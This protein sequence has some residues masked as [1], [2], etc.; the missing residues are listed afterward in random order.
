VP[1][2]LLINQDKI[3]HYR[4]R[5]YNYL[6]TFL[7]QQD[8]NLALVS[9][10]VEDGNSHPITFDHRVISLRTMP[11]ARFIIKE[12]P[13]IIIYWIKL[14][15]MYLFPVLFMVKFLGKKS[16]YWGHGRDLYGR[17]ALKLKKL[18]HHL[19]FMLS[20]ALLLYGEHLKSGVSRRFHGKTFTANNTLYFDGYENRPVDR[21][22]CLARFGISTNKNII[23]IGRM[24]KRKRLEDLFAAFQ[25]I[26]RKDVGLILV[27]PD[28][29]RILEN[30]KGENIYKIGPVYGDERLDL[31]ASADVFCLPGAIGLSIID[32][33]YCGLPVVTET[34]EISPEI[35]YLKDGINGF[36][37][38]H[39]DV[40]QL[41]A[42]LELLLG[43][44][45]LRAEFSRAARRE[46]KTNGHIDR[47]CE[48]FLA[49]LRFVG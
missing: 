15:H 26:N 1:R 25:L 29:D 3:P 18:G 2:V 14:R 21:K 10:G 33:M 8:Y 32:A 41:A 28:E 5:I 17:N 37:V 35:M 20:D 6:S 27:G 46:I 16:I 30:S 23:C 7:A 43:D 44:D 40:R 4:V 45:D 22:K 13:D 47:L 31:L 48:G 11:L 36:A 24:Q 42:K 9:E 49:A 34:G 19:E 39:G 12:D 38:P